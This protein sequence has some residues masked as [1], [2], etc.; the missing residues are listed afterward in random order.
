MRA[1][2]ED[3]C[4]ATYRHKG[5]EKLER[6][7]LLP[8]NKH[9]A[10]PEDQRDN[11]VDRRLREGVQQGAPARRARRGLHGDNEAVAVPPAAVVLP[12]ERCDGADRGRSLARYLRRVDVC[13]SVLFV[14]EDDYA[15][16][17]YQVCRHH[18]FP[19][20]ADQPDIPREEEQGRTR[21]VIV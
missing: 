4:N 3:V 20:N 6:R 17:G 10:V 14:F 1:E 2:T 5:D 8:R 18:G 15:L 16:G 9:G 7:A 19:G 11:P 13:S 12:G 21:Y